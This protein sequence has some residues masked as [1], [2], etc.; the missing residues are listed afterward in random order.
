MGRRG[1]RPDGSASVEGEKINY[2]MKY[3]PMLVVLTIAGSDS[4][5]GAGIQ[6]DI[7]ALASMG[8]HG[9]S[10]IT[11]VTSQNT[12]GVEA[13]HPMP[14]DQIRSQL[15]AILKDAKISAAKTGMLYSAEIA[16][17]VAAA[18]S[19]RGFPVVVDPVLAAGVGDSLHSKNLLV[20]LKRD[21]I[22][23]AAVVTPNVPEAEALA[24][25]RIRSKKDRSMAC[26]A[27]ASMGA[28]AVLLKGGHL[29]GAMAIDT[30]YLGGEI[31]ELSSPRIEERGHGGGCVLA[32]YIAGYLAM[33]KDVRGAAIA[34]KRRIFDAIMLNYAVGK[35]LRI[36]NPLGPA[37]KEI[38]RYRVLKDLKDAVSKL[39][40]VLPASWVPE[41]GI[42]FAFA[43]P[44]ARDTDEVCGIEGRIASISGRLAHGGC[45]EF[46][47]SK[48]VATIVLTAMKYDNAM[49]SAVNVR[50]S[51]NSIVALRRAGMRIGSFDRSE[52]PKRR[53]TMEWGT[54]KVIEEM[55]FVPDVVFDRG[56][57]GKE[58]MIRIL[59]K[60]P[61]EVVKKV[62]LA[63][64][65]AVMP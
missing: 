37:D 10:V 21:I 19:K 58:P 46:G 40:S 24:G 62:R 47:A 6:A 63:L 64:D 14:A 52:E 34:A 30:L 60:D 45:F 15:D 20:A 61:A 7:K 5:G 26:E 22:P 1:A 48:H 35:G 33:G 50:Y 23:M 11:A 39:E 36:V 42:N 41:V 31:E 53:K 49:R 38:L 27:L 13:I 55:G 32:S 12:R 25:M 59:G 16:E 29:R 54:A 3:S 8:I 18:V 17:A 28:K 57:I 56:G 44:G 4:I 65:R 43:L 51:E 2:E 9:A